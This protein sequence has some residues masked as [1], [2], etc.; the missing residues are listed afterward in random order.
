MDDKCPT[1][2]ERREQEESKRS[3]NS[4]GGE[5]PDKSSAIAGARKNRTKA[6]PTFITMSPFNERSKTV[7]KPS[8]P[9]AQLMLTFPGSARN[10]K[11]GQEELAKDPRLERS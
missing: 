11:K 9:T 10:L 7:Y 2:I 5:E 1:S 8:E 3:K 6:G 4:E